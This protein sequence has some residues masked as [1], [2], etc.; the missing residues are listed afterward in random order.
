LIATH[1]DGGYRL[2]VA[3]TGDARKTRACNALDPAMTMRN[4]AADQNTMIEEET[5]E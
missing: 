1:E 3:A 2:N 4:K 5:C